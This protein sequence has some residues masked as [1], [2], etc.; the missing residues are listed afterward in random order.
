[1]TCPLCKRDVPVSDA[2][3]SKQSAEQGEIVREPVF[4]FHYEKD[5]PHICRASQKTL[6][7]VEEIAFP[8][9]KKG[10]K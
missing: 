1:M 9:R 4:A 2:V 10:R 5:S 8:K 7:A 6:S 3:L